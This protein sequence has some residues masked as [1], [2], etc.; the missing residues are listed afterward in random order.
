MPSEDAA[1]QVEVSTNSLN[2]AASRTTCS[3]TADSRAFEKE[4]E[5]IGRRESPN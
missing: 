3:W 4:K 5:P 2:V 1:R